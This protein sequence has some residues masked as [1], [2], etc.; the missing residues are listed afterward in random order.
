MSTTTLHLE[1]RFA[2]ALPE[3]AV[4]WQAEAAP[5]PTLLALDEQL[6][7]ELGLDAAWLRSGEG[8]RLLTG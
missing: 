2:D 8:L 1:H 3:L 7:T 4:D 5:G 6:A